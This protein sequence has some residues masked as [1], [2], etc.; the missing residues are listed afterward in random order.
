[1]LHDKNTVAHESIFAASWEHEVFAEHLARNIF[2]LIDCIADVDALLEAILPKDT[3]CP[4]EPLYLSLDYELIL[5]VRA[6]LSADSK[7]FFGT[8]SHGTSWDRD[9]ILVNELGRLVFVQMN[10]SLA[11]RNELSR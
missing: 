4:R 10:P 11:H 8:E 9:H 1:M 6:E 5:E 3:L 7:G 2:H